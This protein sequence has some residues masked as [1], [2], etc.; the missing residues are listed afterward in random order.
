MGSAYR[1]LGWRA[2]T[3]CP[4]AA[5]RGAP[6][7]RILLP[8]KDIAVVGGGDTAMEEATFLT[9]FANRSRSCTGATSCAP[10]RSCPSGPE[11][12]E[13]ALAWNSEVVDLTAR[14][15][16]GVRLRDT[17]TGEERDLESVGCS[18]RSATNRAANW[19]RQNRPRR[20]GL[21]P[22]DDGHADQP[23][24]VFA[25]GDL[26]DHTYRQAITA[27]GTGCQAR[28]TSSA[29][30]PGSPTSRSDRQPQPRSDQRIR[31]RR[32]PAER[33]GA[34]DFWAVAGSLMGVQSPPRRAKAGA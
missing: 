2:R 27:A 4:G 32:E 3:N 30:S 21:R 7:R 1:R 24:G 17:V 9:R 20:R 15:L 6:L 11:G 25:A 29:T 26:V 34:T 28:S 23:R 10:A 14:H 33:S 12:P 31:G 8:R 19:P 22:H 16:S 13:D 5:C 18:S